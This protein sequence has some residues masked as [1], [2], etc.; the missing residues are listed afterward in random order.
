MM[1]AMPDEVEQHSVWS[2]QPYP[3]SSASVHS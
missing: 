2:G 1:A 3:S